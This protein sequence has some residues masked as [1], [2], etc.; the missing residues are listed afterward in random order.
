MALVYRTRPTRGDPCGNRASRLAASS[1]S[2]Y[3][4]ATAAFAVL[5]KGAQTINAGPGSGYASWDGSP[6]KK[7][8][9]VNGNAGG[10]IDSGYCQDGWFDWFTGGPHYDARASRSCQPYQSRYSGVVQEATYAPV[11]GMQRMGS[12]YGPNN[13]TTS[14]TCASSKY[15]L[16][17]LEGVNPRF[18]NYS[19]RDWI[20]DSG[21][22]LLYHSGGSP[23]S[24]TS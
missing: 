15:A 18:P 21:G 14:G 3:C 20:R 5:G 11:S 16:R 19:T 24:P 22:H 13:A 23:T 1:V 9:S 7:T 4:L 12:C 17:N 6:G 2:P 10:I 8:V